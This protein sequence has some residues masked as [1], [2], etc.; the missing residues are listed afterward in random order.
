ME[1]DIILGDIHQAIEEAASYDYGKYTGLTYRQIN[2]ASTNLALAL[3][4]LGDLAQRLESAKVKA[5]RN[6]SETL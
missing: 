5:F 4:N 1:F 3:H 2:Q 6:E